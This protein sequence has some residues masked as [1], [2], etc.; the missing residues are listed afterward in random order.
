MAFKSL[1]SC[2]KDI[3]KQA[4]IGYREIIVYKKNWE[5]WRKE[6]EEEVVKV[7]YHL[8]KTPIFWTKNHL[9]V[10]EKMV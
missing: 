2:L 1:S 9:F 4:K 8:H 10:G 6:I 3:Q 5:T 7:G